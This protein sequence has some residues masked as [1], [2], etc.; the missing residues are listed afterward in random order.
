LRLDPA[1]NLRAGR[2]PSCLTRFRIPGTS[3][4]LPSRPRDGDA[5]LPPP[6][7]VPGRQRPPDAPPTA[8][9]RPGA[10]SVYG[11]NDSSLARPNARGTP[12]IPDF[13]PEE[14]AD[15]APGMFERPRRKRRKGDA[16]PMSLEVGNLLITMGVLGFVW[17]L[18]MAFLVWRPEFGLIMLLFGAMTYVIGRSWFLF[19]AWEEGLEGF[20]RCIIIPFYDWL[21]LYAN[22]ERYGRAFGVR[23]FGA[24]TLA[25]A[26]LVYRMSGKQD[27]FDTDDPA[28]RPAQVRPE[29]PRKSSTPPPAQ[30]DPAP[31]AAEEKRDEPPAE[32]PPKRDD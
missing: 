25:V 32:P 10:G 11:V 16:P 18:L 5:H 21:Y 29:P 7:R 3:A 12:A 19:I 14:L 15:A 1:R 9:E 31:P 17:L 8:L 6:V 22:F 24:L 2:C 26:A 30:P 28:P 23:M 20:F 13:L 27:L 4:P